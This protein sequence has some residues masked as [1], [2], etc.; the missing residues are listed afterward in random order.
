MPAAS[1]RLRRYIPTRCVG[2]RCLLKFCPRRKFERNLSETDVED[3]TYL[4][5]EVLCREQSAF[6]VTVSGLV[7]ALN[8]AQ[9]CLKLGG[10]WIRYNKMSKRLE[11]LYPRSLMESFCR[12]PPQNRQSVKNVNETVR[13]QNKCKRLNTTNRW[14]VDVTVGFRNAFEKKWTEWQEE[15]PD[16]AIVDAQ[17]AVRTAVAAAQGAV[18]KDNPFDKLREQA[19]GA[20]AQLPT[21]RQVRITESR[22][23]VVRHGDD[24]MRRGVRVVGSQKLLKELRRPRRH[25]RP[26]RQ[27]GR[28]PPVRRRQ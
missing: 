8:I 4:P 25:Q 24:V 22:A 11:F 19:A 14:S 23:L 5:F 18:V 6:G 21:K 10:R 28:H 26:R 1:I 12:P 20:I 2:P 7:A 17:S 16:A 27:H 13:I 3:G 9:A 15:N